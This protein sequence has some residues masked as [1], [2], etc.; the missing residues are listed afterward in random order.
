MADAE[1]TF[2]VVDP[3]SGAASERKIKLIAP[4]SF[5]ARHDLVAAV[6]S[7]WRRGF[8]AALAMCWK[9][10]GLPKVS[11]QACGFDA[12]KYGGLVMDALL[13]Q[14][15]KMPELIQA[16]SAAWTLASAD[17]LAEVDVAEAEGNSEGQ[18]E[19]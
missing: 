13:E 10:P 11:Y 16:G 17:I 2:H 8:M 18:Q 15:Y 1:F 7:N 3:A 9:G 19:E 12:L 14:G 5:A 4:K 6:G